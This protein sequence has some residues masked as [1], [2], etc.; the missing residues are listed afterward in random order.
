MPNV[1]SLQEKLL[2][3]LLDV[4]KQRY[5]ILQYL[6]LMGPIGRRN[7]ATNLGLTER[8]LRKEV[9]FLQTQGLLD[10]SVRGMTLTTEGI[11]LLDDLEETMKQTSGLHDMEMTLQQKLQLSEVFIVPGDSDVAPWVKK[12]MG[13][14]CIKRLFQAL[15]AEN[16]IA[17]A[18]GTTLATVS[19]MMTSVPDQQ[20]LLF[21]PARGGLG[22]Q[23]GNQA[24]SIAARMAEKSHTDYRLLHVPDQ[25]SDS[26]Y[27]SMIDE[28]S[29]K[30]VLAHIHAADIV[31]HGIGDAKT[32]AVRRKS[33]P[34]LLYEL[35]AKD[36]VAE[37]FGYYFDRHGQIVHKVKTVGMQLDE[38]QRMREI[39]AV[40][41][42]AS[43][44]QA[45]AAFL[46]QTPGSVLVTDEGAAKELVRFL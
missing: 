22:E 45:I 44:A 40:A 32:M 25:L 11:E 17:V 4:M 9:E 39:F 19:E 34:D 36:A 35:E 1:I 29:I 26:A 23:V 6:R 7:L 15:Q 5:H 30:D 10:A 18:G 31:V 24:N 12:D 43:K 8:V 38:L 2:P 33:S 27:Q 28:P 13:R 20:H 37:A 21:V 46:Q 3:D 41:G 42:G 14:A 16:T